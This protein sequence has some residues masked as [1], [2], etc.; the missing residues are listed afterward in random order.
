MNDHQEKPL[1]GADNNALV[2]LMA[3]NLVIAA[4]LGF[5]KV[6]YYLEG[7]P[8]ADFQKEV[9]Q[10]VVLDPKNIA[11][12]IWTVFSFNWTHD[13]F[14][15]L[16]TNL[17]WLLVFGKILQNKGY[18][19]H[20]FPLYFY[21]G[22]VA[23]LSYILHKGSSP[24]LG[25]QA[26]V[27]AIAVAAV[28]TAPKHQLFPNLAYVIPTWMVFV[29]YVVLTSIAM[30]AMPHLIAFS[31]VLGGMMGLLYVVLLKKGLDLGKWMHQLI[32]FINQS[33]A[34]KNNG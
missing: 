15:I 18:N 28:M 8:I 3:V 27:L 31:I 7:F 25:A 4:G 24:F 9:Y 5:M 34:P 11:H 2:A 10:Y 1:W 26:S 12:T 23:G 16:F 13:G 19:K 22:L 33:L 21:S 6:T 32:H 20:L 30:I 29:I 17:F 14:W